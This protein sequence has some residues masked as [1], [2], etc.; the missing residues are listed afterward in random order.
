MFDMKSET[1]ML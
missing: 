1:R